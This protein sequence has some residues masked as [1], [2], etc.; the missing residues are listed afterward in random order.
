MSIQTPPIV[1]PSAKPFTARRELHPSIEPLFQKLADL[2]SLPVIAQKVIQVAEDERSDADDLLAVIEQDAAVA[3]RLMKV[4]NS[5]YCGTR[6]SVSDLKTAVTMLGV[7]QVRNLALAVS[8]GNLFGRD[9]PIGQLDPE[10]LWDH[11]VCVATVSRLVAKRGTACSPDEAYLAGLI[12]DLGLL[13]I[14]QHLSDLTPRVLA[15]TETGLSL[16][17]SEREVLGFD[18][19]QLGAYVAWR[20]MF[21]ER[22]VLALDYH[23][24]PL[25]C[26]EEGVVLASVVSVSNYL[27]TRCGR[28]SVA[29]RRLPP[30][31]DLL[32]EPLGL[33]MPGLR[34]VWD[35]LPDAMEHVSELTGL[36]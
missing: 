1:E 34:E 30:P 31:T 20:S 16:C 29:G 14:N 17:E 35:E 27:T 36:V 21:P 6:G 15:R 9:T 3:T 12:H 26:P 11:S 10:R 5:S 24:D 18:H 13:F 4:V 33:N 19:A 7:K 23:H 28:G 32:L 25:H 22:L 2:C 8:I